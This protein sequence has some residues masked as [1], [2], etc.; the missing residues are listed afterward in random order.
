MHRV[1]SSGQGRLAGHEHDLKHKSLHGR[2]INDWTVDAL[3]DIYKLGA[4]IVHFDARITEATLLPG[5]VYFAISSTAGLARM[6][7]KCA[8]ISLG[9]G[10]IT[11]TD[12]KA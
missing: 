12:N 3:L 1:C 5:C 7:A 11:G 9:G 4:C 2:L 10:E 6:L 8:S